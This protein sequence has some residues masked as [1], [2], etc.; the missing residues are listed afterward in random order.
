MSPSPRFANEIAR[1]MRDPDSMRDE[2]ERMQHSGPHRRY[3]PSQ[4][5]V[6]AGHS[7]GGQWTHTGRGAGTRAHERPQIEYAGLTG[8][9]LA[10]VVA[11]HVPIERVQAKPNQRRAPNPIELVDAARLG[12]YNELTV[13]NGPNQQTI[14]ESRAAQALGTNTISHRT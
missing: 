13:H 3:D 8:A 11:G 4:P 1:L 9:G 7:D 12:L 6:P 14:V 2:W 10:D 5:R